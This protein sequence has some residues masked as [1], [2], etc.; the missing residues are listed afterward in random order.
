[1]SGARIFEVKGVTG[2]GTETTQNRRVD[3][4]AGSAD[5]EIGAATG[6]ARGPMV[7]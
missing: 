5:V 1:V 6:Q 3:S 2:R 7:K 4:E